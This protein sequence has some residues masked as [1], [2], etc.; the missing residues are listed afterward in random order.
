VLS[1]GL[2]EL[3]PWLSEL[4]AVA[5]PW[6][7]VLNKDIL[8]GVL[9]DLIELLSNDHLH[10][11]I[12]LLWN[13]LGLEA[14]GDL[15]SENIVD[16]GSDD[17]N[18]QISGLGL[19]SVLLHAS[20]HDSSQGWEHGFGDS[21]EL[22]KSL[23]NAIS[24]V[25]VGEKHLTLVGLGGLLEGVHESGILVRLVSEQD[26]GGLLLSED[27][28]D[29][30]LGELKDSW[31]HEWFDESGK[32]VLV[33][34]ALV[35][36]LGGLELSEED[37]GWALDTLGGS[38]S[39]ILNVNESNLVLGG[40]VWE[41]SLGEKSIIGLSEVG[42]DELVVLDSLGKSIAISGGGWWARLLGNP[43]DDG[44]LGSASGVLSLLSV[45]KV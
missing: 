33:G 20:W 41:V 31:D 37:D 14:W 43:L 3:L 5:A 35:L 17:I 7:V 34:L 28:L 32:G 38:A 1:H 13:W 39:G 9:D 40:G 42:N 12:I 24:D 11:L 10:W 15:A 4:L 8:G 45:P 26:E 25:T 21:H 29:L 36:V 23:L 2:G 27:S 18:G 19:S 44:V 22:T 16:E 6:G 30:I